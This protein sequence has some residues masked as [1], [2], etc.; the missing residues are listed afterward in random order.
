VGIEGFYEAFAAEVAPFG[1][2]TI[3]VE[4]GLARTGFTSSSADTAERGPAYEGNPARAVQCFPLE[5]MPGDPAK[6]AR[7]M[8]VAA[9]ADEPPRRLVLGSDAYAMARSALKERL[10]LVEAQ[11]EHARSTDV[12]GWGAV[13][14]A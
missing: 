5:A 11:R 6:M 2:R 3:L 9:G 12:D 8:I 7:A 4:P 14:A 10:D 13:A 1:I